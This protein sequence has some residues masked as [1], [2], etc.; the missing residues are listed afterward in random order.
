MGFLLDLLQA[1]TGEASLSGALG[2][3][4]QAVSESIDALTE[5]TAILPAPAPV[6]VRELDVIETERGLVLQT[7]TIDTDVVLDF[8]RFSQGQVSYDPGL[9][10]YTLVPGRLYELDAGGAVANFTDADAGF[11]R[12]SW[13]DAATNAPL[14]TEITGIYKPSTQTNPSSN[15][16]RT[17]AVFRPTGATDSRVK[18]RV[19]DAT[20]SADI[21]LFFGAIVKELR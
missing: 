5:R 21:T 19:T 15:G 14:P 6:P 1:A 13:V 10:I 9:G 20:G 16:G 17:R 7:V 8:V 12:I 3:W 18:L 11:L 2:H 4:R